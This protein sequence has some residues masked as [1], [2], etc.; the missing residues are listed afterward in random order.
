MEKLKISEK[1]QSEIFLIRKEYQEL[2]NN[3]KL[4]MLNLL[5]E[6]IKGQKELLKGGEG[7]A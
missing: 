1:P 2:S 4:E 5:Q 7:G 3:K 6:W